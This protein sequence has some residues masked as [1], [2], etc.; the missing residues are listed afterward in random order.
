[1]KRRLRLLLF[2][3]LLLLSGC[4]SHPAVLTSTSVVAGPNLSGNWQIQSAPTAPVTPVTGVLLL[5]ALANSG[6]QVSGTFRFSNLASVS[7]CTLN[8]VV[9]LTGSIDS[10]RSLTLTSPALADGT[11]I[12]L[13][14]LIPTV[15][16]SFGNGTIEVSGTNCGFASGPAFG[17]EITPVTGTFS[18]VLTP[19][20]LPAPVTNGPAGTGV[21]NLTQASVPAADGQF[22]V[23]GNLAYTLGTCIGNV[24]LSGTAS[25]VGLSLAST[26]ALPL[27]LPAARLNAIV[28][29]LSGQLTID[30]AVFVSLSCSNGS[31]LVAASYTGAFTAQ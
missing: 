2:V 16:T 9:T 30:K 21:L 8:Q 19:T 11:V 10:A 23:T 28:N 7:T 18:G 20:S 4:G 3:P 5:G 6:N 26:P 24:A 27:S 31:S 14:L 1:M 29:L 22:P 15:L 17:V 13:Q 25:G 12:K